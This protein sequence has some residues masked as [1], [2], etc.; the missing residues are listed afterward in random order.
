LIGALSS[1]LIVSISVYAAAPSSGHR[2][3]VSAAV[4]ADPPSPLTDATVG[5]VAETVAT[6]VAGTTTGTISDTTTGT[7][8]DTTTATISDTTTATI[9]DTTTGTI[10]ATTTVVAK[11]PSYGGANCT[12]GHFC[13]PE[14]CNGSQPRD[15]VAMVVPTLQGKTWQEYLVQDS[16]TF[17]WYNLCTG[18]NIHF[19]VYTDAETCT[20]N[21]ALYDRMY[22]QKPAPGTPFSPV[23]AIVVHV[24]FYRDCSHPTTT[25]PPPVPTP[26]PPP[27]PSTTTAPPPSPSTTTAPVTTTAVPTTTAAS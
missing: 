27:Q 22:S 20:S 8:S 6:T 21:P 23:G 9:S 11:V 18:R 17:Y 14:K 10:R 25:Y 7:I 15:P 13:N 4:T 16:F 3:G 26:P 1:V 5:T 12:P 24:S 19:E 2:L